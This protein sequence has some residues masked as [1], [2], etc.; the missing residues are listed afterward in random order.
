MR[1]ISGSREPYNSE[2]LTVA[3]QIFKAP[4]HSCP[5][6]VIPVCLAKHHQ[7]RATC[8]SSATRTY[9]GF[10]ILTSGFEGLM[11]VHI[12][13]E[14]SDS[15]L[16]TGR[17]T[18]VL[19]QSLSPSCGLLRGCSCARFGS[20]HTYGCSDLSGSSVPCEFPP[21]SLGSTPK[22]SKPNVFSLPY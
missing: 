16:K 4:G 21:R 22:V 15:L 20:T 7:S 10:I 1:T 11:T 17:A 12:C 6:L 3:L 18:T 19:F 13:T 9:R 8:C 2:H 5:G 14:S